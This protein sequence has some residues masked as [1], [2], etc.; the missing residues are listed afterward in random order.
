MNLKAMQEA[1]AGEGLDGW[2]FFD[3]HGRDPLAYRIL[4]LNPGRTATRRWYYFVPA[5]GEPRGLVHNIEPAALDGLPGDKARYSSWTEQVDGLARMLS[6]ARRVAMQYSPECRVPYVA[7]VDAG[8]VELVR[9][10]GV[11]VISSADL[12]QQFEARWTQANLDSHL[13]AGRKVDEIRRDAFRL[14]GAKLRAAE[15][16]T[17][18]AVKQFIRERF[19]SA[20]LFTDHGP[21]VGVNENSSNPHYEPQADC[22]SEI[23]K[24]DWLL[25]DMWAKEDAADG[26][27]YDITWTGYC[28]MEAPSRMRNV[29]EV[30]RGARERAV[31]FVREQVGAGRDLRGFEV[32]D[33]ARGF[34]RERGF[35]DAFFHRTGHSIGAEVHGSGANMDNLETHDERR[36]IPWTCFSIEPGIYLPEFGVRSEVNVFVGEG[37]ARV[38]GEAQQQIVLV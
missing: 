14:V 35:G 24:G 27:Y 16:I 31:A 1:V 11:E 8:T 30:V 6:G 9:K 26:V 18:F 3:H 34:I 25:I 29:F 17:E 38:T 12:V 20:G 23:R 15:T 7:M 2:L 22:T 19:A 37:E 32:D 28:G 4:G 13:E 36:V 5:K 33:A 21:I 10:A